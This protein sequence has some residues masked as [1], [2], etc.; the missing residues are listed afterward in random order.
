MT[1]AL[2]L[3]RDPILSLAS[4]P[5]RLSPV[6]SEL[7]RLRMSWREAR[8]LRMERGWAGEAGEAPS[9]SPRRS[10]WKGG[11]VMDFEWAGAE[12]WEGSVRSGEGEGEEG[13]G[14]EEGDD[15]SG[16]EGAGVGAEGGGRGRKG[17]RVEGGRREDEG[18][19]DTKMSGAEWRRLRSR[20]T[21]SNVFFPSSGTGG[22][23]GR[24]EVGGEDEG[25]IGCGKGGGRAAGGG[26]G[27]EVESVWRWRRDRMVSNFKRHR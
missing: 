5:A 25:F 23:G 15:A 20:E 22:T 11:G 24:G 13:S 8:L 26:A 19:G 16:E 27:G 14:R 17:D 3:A 2:L 10:G 1:E 18:W 21:M 9:S 4:S 7:E 6:L 12:G